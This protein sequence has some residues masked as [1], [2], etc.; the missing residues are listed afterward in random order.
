MKSIKI[1]KK[2]TTAVITGSLVA[3]MLIGCGE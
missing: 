3:T 1:L 2:I